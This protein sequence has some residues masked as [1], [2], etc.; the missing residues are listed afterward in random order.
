[1]TIL[2]GNDSL[3]CLHLHVLLREDAR[4]F[5]EIF[6]EKRQ[7]IN[8]EKIAEVCLVAG[9]GLIFGVILGSRSVAVPHR[10]GR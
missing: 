3:W 4:V 1:M 9:W 2:W 10:K 5:L 8:A 7:N 6:Q